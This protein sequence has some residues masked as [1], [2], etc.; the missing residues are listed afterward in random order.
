MQQSQQAQRQ[1]DVIAA[2][3]KESILDPRV[4]LGVPPRF[5]RVELG[6]DTISY[7]KQKHHRGEFGRFFP[8]H[9]V[10]TFDPNHR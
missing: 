6:P 3:R 9:I 2:S 10:T 4:P 7:Y 1:N 8:L 5:G